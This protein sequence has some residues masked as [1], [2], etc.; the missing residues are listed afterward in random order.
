[1][2]LKKIFTRIWHDLFYILTPG[3]GLRFAMRCKDVTAIIDLGT[4]PEEWTKRFRFRLH[5]SLCEAC[6][7]YQKITMVLNRAA[8]EMI[9]ANYAEYNYERLNDALLK[10]YT[11]YPKA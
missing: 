11:A 1:M 8:R 6:N 4:M 3:F 9:H 7:H 10:K 2:N 5:L